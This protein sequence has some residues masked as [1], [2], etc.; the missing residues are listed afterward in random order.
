[1]CGRDWYRTGRK[2]A[3]QQ[4]EEISKVVQERLELK[5]IVFQ[6][7]ER[8]YACFALDEKSG[9]SSICDI[10]GRVDEGHNCL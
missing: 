7:G 8:T 2:S 6:I 5:D 3:K 9:V 4:L 10:K 1:M